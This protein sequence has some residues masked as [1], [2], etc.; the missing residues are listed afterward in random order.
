[1]GGAPPA[2][3]G[4]L[5]QSQQE[6]PSQQGWTGAQQGC[7]AEAVPTAK[8]AK[9]AAMTNFFIRTSHP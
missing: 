8:K 6:P 2:I 3:C 1:M 9:S 4:S 7:A 5:F